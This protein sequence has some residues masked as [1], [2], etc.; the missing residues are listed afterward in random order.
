MARVGGGRPLKGRG[1]RAGRE[2]PDRAPLHSPLMPDDDAS[3]GGA[4]RVPP[5]E[6]RLAARAALQRKRA[7]RP[8]A[9]RRVPFPLNWVFPDA[10]VQRAARQARLYD[11]T[12]RTARARRAIAMRY[13][14][15][16]VLRV[17]MGLAT[18][19]CLSEATDEA[20]LLR[21][22]DDP[23]A[24]PR[25][26]R[27][28]MEVALPAEEASAA[29][30]ALHNVRLRV[31]LAE[32]DGN[33]TSS[34]GELRR[35]SWWNSSVA[36]THKARSAVVVFPIEGRNK[37]CDVTARFSRSGSPTFAAWLPIAIATASR[38]E[39][40][41]FELLSLTAVVGYDGGVPR[42]LDLLA[43]K[44]QPPAPPPAPPR[45]WYNLWLW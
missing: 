10:T 5:S 26:A 37:A 3:A 1:S 15:G 17:S 34:G 13:F 33:A 24:I 44:R 45:R 36:I 19:Y 4:R 30:I 35:G 28:D 21:L 22:L 38:A 18:V 7:Q 25:K 6:E 12:T 16:T 20:L 29:N 8:E 9:A 23:G 41:A 31:A 11:A 27:D 14:G 42:R 43:P 32:E 2:G 39:K 40:P